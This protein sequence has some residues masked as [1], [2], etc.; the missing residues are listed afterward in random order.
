MTMDIIARAMASQALALGGQYPEVVDFPSLPAAAANTGKDYIVQTAT[1]V[2]PINRKPAGLYRSNGSTWS[3]LG[4]A[5]ST[6]S[7]ITNVPAGNIVATDVQGALNS[8]DTNK[9]AAPVVQFKTTGYTEGNLTGD[10]MI[11]ANLAAGFTIILPPATAT[12]RFTFKKVQ[13]AGV[14]TIAAGGTDTIEGAVSA[15]LNNAGEA[16]TVKSDQVS[17]WNVI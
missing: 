14:I 2:W 16:I 11:L 10:V 6:A 9:L 12:V 17:N 1:G 15:L 8:L 7:L 5:P 13:S 4:D 3:W